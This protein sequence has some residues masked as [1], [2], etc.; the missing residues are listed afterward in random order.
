MFKTF[1]KDIATQ[2]QFQRGIQNPVSQTS[3]MECFAK[4]VNGF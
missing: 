2:E 4:M 1:F 3:K